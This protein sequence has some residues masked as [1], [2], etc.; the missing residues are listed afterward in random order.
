LR[1][2]SAYIDI[3]NPAQAMDYK[4]RRD[5]LKWQQYKISQRDARMRHF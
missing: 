5:F 4:F 2:G 1:L 3:G